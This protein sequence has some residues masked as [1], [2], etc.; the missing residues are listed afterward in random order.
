MSAE[1]IRKLVSEA[2]E[3][4]YYMHPT[5]GLIATITKTKGKGQDAEE[6]TEQ[7]KIS[8]PFE[9]LGRV[10]DPNGEGWARVLRWHDADGK[11]HTNHVSDA[12]LHGDP[13][14][15][16]A[17]LARCGLEI[18][19]VAKYRVH[20][21][22][23][24]NQDDHPDRLTEVPTTGWHDASGGK[25]FALPH[26]M[27]GT[28]KGEKVIVRGVAD[29]SPFEKRGTLADWQAG[30]GSLVA[31]HTRA[32]FEVSAAIA[33]PLLEP[34]G[35]EGG[36]FH[37]YGRSSIGKT[38]LVKAAAS[39]WGKG[40]TDPGFVRS[41]RS[42]AN[43]L[44]AVAALHTDTILPLDELGVV[45][46]KEAAAAVYSLSGGV[47]KGRA[48]REGYARRSLTWR[49]IILSTG[50]IRLNDKLIEDRRKP[51]VGQQ[52]R[53][54]DIPA[55]AGHGFGAFDSAGA[56]VSA[57]ILADKIKVAAQ[58]HHGTAGPEFVRNLIA[59][60]GLSK[61]KQMIESFQTNA[62]KDA[63]GQVLRVLERFG[64]VAAAGE[65]AIQFSIVPWQKGAA[66]RSAKVCF[67]A[68]FADRGGAGAGEDMAAIAQVRHFIEK[69]GEARFEP[70][71]AHDGIPVRDRAGWR[72]GEG[73]ARQW[74][75]LP[76]TWRTDVCTGFNSTEVAKVLAKRGMLTPD[77]AGRK[78]SRNERI[79]EGQKPR[80]VYVVTMAIIA[81]EG[82]DG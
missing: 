15:L 38:T 44:E 10:R 32:V 22:H 4:P 50:E 42:T 51:R 37:L 56:E 52:V 17:E 31:G 48:N 73:D 9:I 34:L 53:L 21:I 45:E 78:Y 8:G 65:L 39:V 63:D 70:V 36:G 80:R 2:E 74:L 27:F 3:S 5:K 7:V 28:V 14:A 13:K 61:I 72:R 19:T 67:D 47:G 40:A 54:V 18:T 35:M 68:W 6:V 57:Q 55:D 16:S 77:D 82:D 29:N 71:N 64:L 81:G 75:I 46:A 30:V 62:P 58:T 79:K 12:Y 49:V 20:L 60:N 41:W 69:H 23:Y 59:D 33:A 24:L 25:I 1:A 66:I 11:Y 43:H 26:E 76:E